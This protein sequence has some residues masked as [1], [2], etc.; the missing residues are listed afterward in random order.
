MKLYLHKTV[1]AALLLL[2]FAGCKMGKNYQRPELA[3]PKQFDAAA[4]G[5]TSSVADLEWKAF[6]TDP[7]LQQLIDKGLHYNNDLLAGLKRME[8]AQQQA[9]QSKLLQLPELGLAV[10]GQISRPSGNSLTGISIKNFLGRSY[11]ENYSASIPLSWEADIWGKI[12][13]QKEIALTD[14][15]RSTEAAKAIRT[16]LVSD[17]SLGYFNLLMLDRQ[18]QIARMNLALSDSFVVA[19]RLIKNAGLVTMLAVEQAESQRQSVA[20]LIPQLEQQVAIQE[21]ALQLLTGQLPS[22]LPRQ[23]E[24]SSISFRDN[25]STGV[26][27]AMVSRRPDVRASELALISANAR[28]GVAQ[29]AMYP[30]LNI[31]AGAGLESF[32]ASNWFSIPGSLFGLATGAIAQPI[33]KRRALRTQFEVAKL[34]REEA[35]IQ[36][37][38]SVLVASTEVANALVQAEKLNQQQQIAK[39]QVDTLQLAVSHAQLLFKSDMATYLEVITAQGNALQAELNLVF[40][41]R[42]QLSARVELYRS[43]GGGWK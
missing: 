2:F 41:R 23:T 15:L 36:F 30:T 26:P 18:L 29:A 28:V 10:S 8:M 4:S 3:L 20:L 38:Q 43:L 31:T 32:Q 21:N 40:I 25:F 1:F 9:K 7:G 24:L 42:Q 12:R 5:D 22:S 35:V 39:G 19:S 16:R 13:R 37:R 6:F 33:F 34:Q 11:L 27:M 14:Y 17:I